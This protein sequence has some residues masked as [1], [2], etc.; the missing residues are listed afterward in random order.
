LAFD[1]C[2]LRS[3]HNNAEYFA[4][5]CKSLKKLVP[6]YLPFFAVT[7]L[8]NHP[9][10]PYLPNHP[11]RPSSRVARTSPSATLPPREPPLCD[12]ASLRETHLFRSLKI[13]PLRPLRL[14][15]CVLCGKKFR[16]TTKTA[17][18][19]AKDAKRDPVGQN[20]PLS[21]H[22]G[23]AGQEG[24]TLTDT[25]VK[26]PTKVSHFWDE[27]DTWD[28]QKGSPPSQG[29]VAAAAPTGW[30]GQTSPVKLHRRGPRLSGLFRT[31]SPRRG[32]RQTAG[33][34]G[35]R[36]LKSNVPVRLSHPGRKTA[37][38]P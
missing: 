33:G 8:P 25:T 26:C 12:F 3:G 32:L 17:K 5:V 36:V 19:I 28:A 22:S 38:P 14:T 20:T 7:R 1:F 29:G 2:V 11:Y 18:K 30:V 6:L 16:L 21:A 27:W 34:Q 9:N 10:R 37:T 24:L 31:S 23:T 4:E 13:L 35:P 15:L